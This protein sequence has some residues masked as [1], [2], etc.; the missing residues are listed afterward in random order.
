MLRAGCRGRVRSSSSSRCGR[1]VPPCPPCELCRCDRHRRCDRRVTEL[2]EAL[3]FSGELRP[4]EG[5]ADGGPA[6]AFQLDG[7]E[8]TLAAAELDE[9]PFS[10]TASLAGSFAPATRRLRL[11]PIAIAS[12]AARVFGS[13][14]LQPQEG[15]VVSQTNIELALE[16]ILRLATW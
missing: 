1:R 6:Y 2:N 15:T 9:P 11:E 13:V 12:G 14:G 16:E 7:S 8:L 5:Q 3:D 10:G 4:Q